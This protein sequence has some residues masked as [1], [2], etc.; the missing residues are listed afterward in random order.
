MLL[1]LVINFLRWDDV[2]ITSDTIIVALSSLTLDVDWILLLL[3]RLQLLKYWQ[4]LLV[5]NVIIHHLL[6]I[7]NLNRLLVTELIQQLPLLLV[8]V[9]FIKVP[10]HPT[11]I[12]RSECAFL[13]LTLYLWKWSSCF[14]LLQHILLLFLLLFIIPYRTLYETSHFSGNLVHWLYEKFANPLTAHINYHG[15]L[16]CVVKKVRKHKVARLL[17]YKT[18]YNSHLTLL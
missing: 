10:L 2:L 3:W 18:Q 1:L 5:L 4:V 9:I 13:R 6:P 15:I 8:V 16:W 7:H 17:L 14:S 11:P 12:N